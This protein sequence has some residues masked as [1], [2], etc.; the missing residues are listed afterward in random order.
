MIFVKH[1]WI[2]LKLI[3]IVD[4]R[5][6]T[7]DSIK[8]PTYKEN[9]R[10]LQKNAFSDQ[11]KLIKKKKNIPNIITWRHLIE[12]KDSLKY[13]IYKPTKPSKENGIVYKIISKKRNDILCTYA[14]YAK[15][16]FG[17][18]RLI[19]TNGLLFEETR[20]LVLKLHFSYSNVFLKNIATVYNAISDQIPDWMISLRDNIMNNKILD[21]IKFTRELS[22]IIQ[23]LMNVI[24]NYECTLTKIPSIIDHLKKQK[25]INNMV[26]TLLGEDQPFA[27]LYDQVVLFINETN[28]S[29]WLIDNNIKPR[30]I[31]EKNSSNG[32]DTNLENDG[33]AHAVQPR[34][35]IQICGIY[36]FNYLKST[37][38]NVYNNILEISTLL[39][40]NKERLEYSNYYSFRNKNLDV[41]QIEI[42]EVVNM[43]PTAFDERY[44]LSDINS[45][46][47]TELLNS[48]RLE[49]NVH[50]I[51]N[52]THFKIIEKDKI[53]AAIAQTTTKND[54]YDKHY[55]RYQTAKLEKIMN[56]IMTDLQ[57]TY[58]YFARVHFN[59]IINFILD[60]H[61]IKI[62]KY[63]TD[64]VKLIFRY[65]KI[66]L[67]TLAGIF[68]YQRQAPNWMVMMVVYFGS[69]HRIA[70]NLD[71]FLNETLK[72]FRVLISVSSRCKN[73][74][75][76]TSEL[77][78]PPKATQV[79]FSNE[80]LN[81]MSPEYLRL[82]IIGIRKNENENQYE[83]KNE[84]KT[85]LL[86]MYNNLIRIMYLLKLNDSYL[87]WYNYNKFNPNYWIF[88]FNNLNQT[89]INILS[90]NPITT[91]KEDLNNHLLTLLKTNKYETSITQ[92]I[93]NAILIH[94]TVINLMQT[95][96]TYYAMNFLTHCRY[97]SFM[98]SMNYL[99]IV[100]NDH[101]AFLMKYNEICNKF[102]KH[103]MQTNLNED[104]VFDKIIGKN[105]IDTNL[106]EIKI[107]NILNKKYLLA[108]RK[109]NQLS[110]NTNTDIQNPN[111][112]VYLNAIV[113]TKTTDEK[114]TNFIQS[115]L[116]KIEICKKNVYIF[117]KSLKD[118]IPFYNYDTY[119]LMLQSINSQ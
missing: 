65:Y 56:V 100:F 86:V 30:D 102:P 23:T 32:Q 42:D 104:N 58:L 103:L 35:T 83:N 75:Y 70:L 60:T 14:L 25:S 44:R 50:T 62:A 78:D 5:N 53:I 106:K 16:H 82:D 19:A 8:L 79:Q 80:I 88:S 47:S 72:V 91:G 22:D 15:K 11:F 29:Q 31:Q 51:I 63:Y 118:N 74:N 7:D 1:V 109:Q 2:I 94:D 66:S 57:C 67:Q 93:R 111:F 45:A 33:T 117:L 43:M 28:V 12:N 90:R 9:I 87:P 38:I 37:A 85:C 34:N 39:V 101:A 40:T 20:E 114:M 6:F 71:S 21:D 55:Y 119:N 97:L 95:R 27:K 46:Y 73:N 89:A 48:K 64:N 18:I 112:V 4:G 76:K 108:M 84:N 26:I 116:S 110:I 77:P 107:K 41:D 99:P 10:S 3:L 61:R 81:N 59:E 92:R 24:S 113:T 36:L 68:Y 52:I 96:I 17:F 115:L 98:V 49:I 54:M 105:Y 69:L 13:G